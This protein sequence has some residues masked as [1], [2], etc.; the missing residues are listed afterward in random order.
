VDNL[1]Y[2]LLFFS[3]LLL[4]FSIVL[5]LKHLK[6]KEEINNKSL[7]NALLNQ[8]LQIFEQNQNNQKIVEEKLKDFF[9]QTSNDA[10]VKNHTTF[11]EMAK[12]TFEQVFEQQK[13]TF[14]MKQTEIKNLLDPV[15]KTLIQM[16][17]KL[18]ELEKERIVAYIDLKT[19]VKGLIEAQSDL[20]SETSNLTKALRSPTTRGQWGELQ[21]KRVVELAGM[22]ERCDFVQQETS[23]RDRLRPDMIVHLPGKKN[24]VIDA[25]TPLAS[26]LSAIDSKNDPDRHRYL[27][28]HA[29]H[30]KSHIKL[31]SQ[32]SYW[33]QFENSPEFVI[34]FIPSEALFSAALEKDPTLIEYGANERVILATPTTLIA[35]LRSIAYGWRQESIHESIKSIVDLGQEFYRRFSIFGGYFS[36]LGK[37]LNQSVDLYNQTL[38]SVENRLLP[39][40]RKFQDVKAIKSDTEIPSLLSIDS[41]TKTPLAQEFSPHEQND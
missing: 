2:I 8:K 41:Q 22:I 19:Q 36:K 18:K 32:K 11:I 3:I 14:D 10:L 35:L 12:S 24:V 33:E 15:S 28:E 31:L 29:A 7:E 4:F 6:Q 34:M 40:V 23:E 1:F 27:S 37:N 21:L 9:N 13:T 5:I 26:Y 16:D 38:G 39:I 30:L 17:E 25:K 20:R